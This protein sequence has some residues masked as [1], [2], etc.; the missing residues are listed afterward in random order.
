MRSLAGL[1]A[2]V[3]AASVYLYLLSTHLPPGSRHDQPGSEG[4]DEGV[5]RLDM[6]LERSAGFLLR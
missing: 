4:G 6:W 5:Q 3:A 2:I 1:A